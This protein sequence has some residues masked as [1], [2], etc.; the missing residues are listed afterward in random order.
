M[1]AKWKIASLVIAFCASAVFTA[2]VCNSYLA[3]FIRIAQCAAA[4]PRPELTLVDCGD[5]STRFYYSGSLYL[6]VDKELVDGL[7]AADVVILGNSRTQR[8]FASEAIDR[9]FRQKGLRYFVLASEGSGFRFSQMIL[10]RAGVRPRILMINNESFM[11]DVLED[12]NRDVVLYPDRFSV[13]LSAFY[14]SKKLQQWIC[15]S[16][17]S[18]LRSFYCHGTNGGWRS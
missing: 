14:Y 12:T 6:L 5:V 11:V 1:L 13:V 15:A 2:I 7:R 8:T 9:Y 17:M 4:P 16:S 18:R 10:E 3:L